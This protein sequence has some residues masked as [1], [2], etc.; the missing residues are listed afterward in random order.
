M[1]RSPNR[2][3]ARPS[4]DRFRVMALFLGMLIGLA[5]SL[6]AQEEGG[7]YQGFSTRVTGDIYGQVKVIRDVDGD[8]KRDMV[9]GATD[10]MVHI[11][12]ASGKE[13]QAGLWP[14]HTGGPILANVAVADLTRDGKDEIIVGSYDG[15]VYCLNSYGKE[16]W[17]VDTRGTIQLSGPEVAD[18]DGTNNLN[19]FVGSRSGKVF[20]IDDAGKLLWEIGLPAKVSARV[21]P[22][23]LNGDGQKE[24]VV[25]DDGGKVSVLQ[26][27]GGTATGWPQG[28]AAGLDWP[29]EV[30]ITDVNGDGER[31][32]FTTTPDKRFILWDRHGNE[33]E[34]F[35][36]SDG[37]HS[38]PKVAD[39]DGDGRDEFIITQ[40][41]GIVNV[42][43]RQGVALPGWPQKTGH[44][45]YAP[46]HIIDIDGDGKL[47]VVFTAWNPEGSGK[48]AGYIMALTKDG[49]KMSGF[50][51]MIGKT[52]APLTFADLDGDG[53][54]EMIAAGGINYTDNQLHVFPTNAKIQMKI[55]VLGSEITY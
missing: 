39:I 44:S 25:K 27:G 9:F 13:I 51:K 48:E 36:L 32:I 40:A 10:G 37:A 12:S 22:A 43:N 31:E 3:F 55:A 47:D 17:T 5:G 21:V 35:K 8:G 29:F 14:K 38:A 15:K 20:R 28:T 53:Y 11:Y 45:I 52:L 4:L 1:N 2:S 46:P 50:P 33:K 7:R 6:P 41:D 16:L 34:T 19:V 24:I 18:I 26:L 23:D 42:V 30:G 54:L 49:K